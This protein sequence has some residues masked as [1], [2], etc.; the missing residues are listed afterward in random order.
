MTQERLLIVGTGAMASLFAARL[1]QHADVT[2]LGTWKE[3]LAALEARG[4]LLAEADGTEESYPVHA[5]VNLED[6]AGSLHALVFVKSWQTS[7]AARQLAECL[8]PE[9]IALTLQNGLGN[10]E[11]LMEALGE[12]RA[13]LG[14]T[15]TGATM[16]GPGHVRV[17]GT[18]PTHVA[19]H[20]RLKSLID[21]LRKAGFMVE[22]A[23]DLEALVWGKLAI[24]AAI[25]PLTALLG[26]P[27]GELLAR[28]HALALMDEAAQE[29]ADVAYARGVKFPF[30]DPGAVAADVAGRTASNL[31]S[32]LQDIQRRAPTEIDA[33][34]GAIALEGESLG[35]MTS[36]NRTLWHLVRALAIS[37]TGVEP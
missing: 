31:S 33:I 26:I 22:V 30:E 36:V 28:P 32:M 17:G 19:L 7:R 14:V 4:V 2:M 21:L 37:A 13:A 18:G 34:C 29:T 12:N 3:G 23:E 11:T 10:L 16:V 15:T 24:N 25:N 1:S 5:T 35:V 6:C 27:N 20:S 9:G 8:D